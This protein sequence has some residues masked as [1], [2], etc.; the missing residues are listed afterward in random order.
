MILMIGQPANELKSTL[1][2]QVSDRANEVLTMTKQHGSVPLPPGAVH[3]YYDPLSIP[4]EAQQPQ[5]EQVAVFDAQRNDDCPNGSTLDVN[6]HFVVYAVKNGLIRVLHRTSTR[7]HL[8]RAHEGRQV[9]DIKFFHEGDVVGTVG[10][11]LVIWRVFERAH[12][13]VAEKLLEFPETIPSMSRMIWHT[14]NPNQFWLIHRDRDNV[15]VA[16]LIETTSISTVVHPTEAHAV[17]RPYSNDVVLENAQQIATESNLT[18]LDWS[19]RD[20]GHVM[21]AHADGSI[22]LWNLRAD[23]SRSPRGMIPVVCMVTIQDSGPVS[24]C[25]F[26]PHDNVATNYRNYLQSDTAVY[27]DPTITNAFCTASRGN[28]CITIW[29]PFSESEVPLK[30][31]VFQIEGADPAYNVSTAFSPSFRTQL[32]GQPGPVF[33]LLSDRIG[34]TMYALSLR[35]IWGPEH[36]DGPVPV[37]LEGFQYVVALKTKFPTYSWS[38]TVVP[39]VDDDD[40]EDFGLDFDIRF[41]ALQS[42]MVQDMYIPKYMLSPPTIEWDEGS[43][44]L[45]VELLPKNAVCRSVHV[46]LYE[47]DSEL[48]DDDEDTE[49]EYASPDPSSL[50]PPD[51]VGDPVERH[52]P[53]ENWLGNLAS[54]AAGSATPQPKKPGDIPVAP[55]PTPSAVNIAQTTLPPGLFAIP[56]PADSISG[57]GSGLLSPLA[58]LSSSGNDS[59]RGNGER[60]REDKKVK[61]QRAA[62]PKVK[63]K[64]RNGSTF[65]A[66]PVPAADGKIAILKRDRELPLVPLT[67]SPALVPLTASPAGLEESLRKAIASHFKAQEKIIVAEVQRAVRQEIK[68]VVLPE[69]SKAVNTTV[70]Q[71]VVRP[72]QSSMEKFVKSAESTKADKIIQAVSSGVE[73]PLKEAFTEVGVLACILILMYDFALTLPLGQSM[74][75]MMIPAFEAAT[76]QM[77][78]QIA[79]ALESQAVPQKSHDD[80]N[81][82]IDALTAMVQSL[83]SEVTKLKTESDSGQQQTQASPQPPSAD[84]IQLVRSEILDLLKSRQYDAAFTKAVSATTAEIA[85]FVCKNANVAEVLGG[86]KPALTQPI[87][88]CLM[89]Q[90]GAAL[91]NSRDDDLKIELMWLQE[92]SLTLDPSDS[93]ISRHVPTVLTQLVTSIETKMHQGDPALRRPLQ[94]ILQVV[95]GMQR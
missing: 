91:A 48:D 10:G 67:S 55:P 18:D 77:F 35:A 2:S 74:K 29:S 1:K 46:N 30:L 7:K 70:E 32:Q 28:S 40:D 83:A 54:R 50:P 58:I 37:L 23:S 14:F 4:E 86:N 51:G 8:L 15:N 93:S 78:S 88:L 45:R 5:A 76:R 56:T 68:Q 79:S 13:I 69:L 17:C 41:Y 38:V 82:K 31:Q 9:T 24:R 94:M 89:Q 73:D 90:L 72:L 39:V 87:L 20:P 21:T 22:K 84:P 11:C 26:L 61:P 62:S 60:Q 80:L 59:A 95:R 27:R 53:F 49:E 64:D 36:V 25:L 34:K 33:V 44:G 75:S 47:E 12:E 66:G 65:P 3:I 19:G 81:L 63:G 52:N 6:H 57:E 71:S 42:R 16:T 43:P 92:I 85:V